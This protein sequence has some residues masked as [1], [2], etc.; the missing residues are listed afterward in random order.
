MGAFTESL[1]D[2][3]MLF[4]GGIPVWLIRSFAR[5]GDVR[6]DKVVDFVNI[7]PSILTMRDGEE[8][9]IGDAEPSRPVVYSHLANKPERYLAMANYIHS[10]I[11]YPLLL[12]SNEARSSVSMRKSALP[13]TPASM[14]RQIS[15]GSSTNLRRVAPC[16]HSF[17]M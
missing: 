14:L 5:F 16:K 13:I 12:G 1:D 15:S 17:S 9:D 8:V 10:F 4:Q 6:I 2:A 11:S 3:D 7:S